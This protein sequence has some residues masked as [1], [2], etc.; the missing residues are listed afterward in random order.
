MVLVASVLGSSLAFVDAS[1]VGVVLPRIQGQLSAGAGSA[2]WIVNAYL[3]TLGGLVLAGG[4]AGDRFGRRRVF[5]TGIVV[6]AAASVM[7]GLATSSAALIAARAIQGLGAALLTPNSLALL[8]SA[9]AKAERGRV[10]GTWAGFAALT[11]ALGPPLG[12]WLTDAASWRA[13]FLINVPLALAAVL[14]AWRFVPESRHPAAARIDWLGALLVTAGLFWLTWGLVA[15]PDRGLSDTRVATTLIAGVVLLALFLLVESRKSAPMV[16]LVLFRS[17]A[18]SAANAVTLL[19]YFALGGALFFLPFDLV[20]AQGYS[21]ARAGAALVPISVVMGLLS[22]FAGK[23]ADRI[24]PRWPL[25]VGSITAGVGLG[26][27]GLVPLDVPYAHGLLPA[28][29]VLALGVTLAV[30]PLTSTVM[31]SVD[32]GRVGIASGVNNAVA[33]IA[34]LL[35]VAAFGVLLSMVFTGSVQDV[36]PGRDGR[37]L[38]A[39]AMTGDNALEVTRL[40]GYFHDAVSKVLV[41]AGVSAALGGVIALLAI[42]AQ[43]RA[44]SA[45]PR[46]PGPTRG[47]SETSVLGARRRRSRSGGPSRRSG[48]STRGSSKR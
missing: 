31:S 27:L 28:L 38:L 40:R 21:A 12:G 19:L 13:V 5:L 34:G 39:E 46:A 47:A 14:L 2:Q 4:A 29:L 3:L 22:P 23:L 43:K 6:F 30:G 8:G 10:F 15:A 17:R 9:F 35:A 20:G 26:L 48:S 16:P 45:P 41:V 37:E 32:E 42:P 36:V 33:R 1:V 44:P 7:C 18:F 24:G 11:S 25:A